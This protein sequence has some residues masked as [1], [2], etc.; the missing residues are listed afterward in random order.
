MFANTNTNFILQNIK[1]GI[2]KNKDSVETVL[3]EDFLN[4]FG[5]VGFAASSLGIKLFDELG[6]VKIFESLISRLKMHGIC[7]FEMH[8][9]DG[10]KYEM[11]IRYRKEDINVRSFAYKIQ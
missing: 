7:I 11:V 4:G 9:P 8:F 1:A 3:I 10:D 6:E 5:M 2:E